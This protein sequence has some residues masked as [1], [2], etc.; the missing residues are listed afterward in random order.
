MV[1]K[2]GVLYHTSF[3]KRVK[4]LKIEFESLKHWKKDEDE[5]M[6]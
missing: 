1:K 5:K 4:R 3:F 6:E 2:S